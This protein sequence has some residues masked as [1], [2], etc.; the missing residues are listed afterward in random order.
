MSQEN[1]TNN[2]EQA[3]VSEKKLTLI[4]QAR[5]TVASALHD[6]WRENRKKEDG[7]YEPRMKDDGLGGQ[8]DIANTDYI[9]LPEKWQGENKIA[10]ETIVNLVYGAKQEG[11]DINSLEFLEEASEAV[12]VEWMKRNPKEEWNAAQH[13]PYAELPE[14]EK[15]KDREH[16]ILAVRYFNESELARGRALENAREDAHH[17]GINRTDEEVNSETARYQQNIQL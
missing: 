11:K 10:A 4:E 1:I 2:I 7:T 12:H 5:I 6:Q 3:I 15:Q 14:T 9:N 8:V 16:V 17:M 13:V